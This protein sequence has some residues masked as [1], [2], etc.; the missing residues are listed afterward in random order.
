M[1]LGSLAIGGAAILAVDGMHEDLSIATRGYQQL[2]QLFDVGFFVSKARQAIS[3]YPPQPQQAVAALQAAEE[4]LQNRSN[5]ASGESPPPRW[6][7]ESARETCRQLISASIAQLTHGSPDASSPGESSPGAPSLNLVFSELSKTAQQVRQSI[8]DAQVAADRKQNITLISIISWVSVVNLAA[9]LIGLGHY[10]RVIG[11]IQK[12]SEGACAFAGGNLQQRIDMGGDLEFV[13]LAH[14][15]NSMARQLSVLYNDLETQVAIKTRELVRSQQLAGVGY[16]AAG[17]AHEINNPLG[18][19]AG[20]GERAQQ[21]LSQSPDADSIQ[22]TKNALA[23]ICEQAFRC[24]QITTQLLSL[25]QPGS[26]DRQVVS[27]PM[28]AETV[29]STLSGLG[30]LHDRAIRLTFDQTADLHVMASEGQMKQMLL[31]LLINAIE[32]V[33]PKAGQIRVAVV[34]KENQVELSVTDNG[35]G[36]PPEMLDQ[37]FQPFFSQK[38]RAENSE[39]R[40]TGLGLCI[41]QSIVSDHAGSIEAASEGSGTGSTFTVRLPAAHTAVLSSVSEESAVASL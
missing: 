7:D 6:V 20:Y 9:I 2:R 35:H 17:V 21:R 22:Q 14:D 23:I 36:I 37:I 30:K 26:P 34:R 1:V 38:L 3:D 39:R 31:N 28:I 15:F 12:L 11:P 41:A 5:S 10:R 4:A 13:T 32:A 24:K 25:A 29:V 16:L 27:M 8:T 19:I 40:G 18:I 33:D